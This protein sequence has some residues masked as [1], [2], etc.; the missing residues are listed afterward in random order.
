MR[1][2]LSFLR[3]KGIPYSEAL[4]LSK[5]AIKDRTEGHPLFQSTKEV[6]LPSTS[7][8]NKKRNRSNTTISPMGHKKLK[9]GDGAVPIKPRPITKAVPSY[10]EALKS[11]QIGIVP[12]KFPMTKMTKDDINHIHKEVIMRIASQRDAMIKPKFTQGT[13][14]RSGWMIFHCAN[15]DTAS[16]LQRQDI[17]KTKDLKTVQPKEF[18]EE[19]ILVGRFKNATDFDNDCILGVIQGSNENLSTNG[20][21]TIHRKE[22]K[23]TSTVILT[24]EADLQS[25]ERLKKTGLQI[26][27][28][29]GQKVKLR[30]IKNKAANENPKPLTPAQRVIESSGAQSS[31]LAKPRTQ[32]TGTK[33]QGSTSVVHNAAGV[34][35]MTP[36]A[37]SSPEISSQG[38]SK[39]PSTTI[40]K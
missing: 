12:T 39:K 1:K 22:E 27:F 36:T 7:G 15:E 13:S 20:W 24:I 8:T 14:S 9:T 19:H 17:W 10:S 2:R 40:K 33:I 34:T 21:R 38:S 3:K 32:L 31:T 29:I 11:F 5:V 23:E 25:V 26:D 35:K 30:L 4:E 37:S 18:P 6:N 28:A 16:W